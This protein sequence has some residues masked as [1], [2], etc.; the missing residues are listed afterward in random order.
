MR[1]IAFEGPDRVGK[2]TQVALVTQK[3]K[4]SGHRIQDY[5]IP[6]KDDSVTYDLI[7]SF[8]FSDKVRSYPMTFQAAQMENRL[9]FQEQVLDQIRADLVLVDRWSLS[10][11]VYG[12]AQGIKS[13]FY[14]SDLKQP[15][16]TVIFDGQPFF[17]EDQD[18]LE[19]DWKLQTKV[20]SLYEAVSGDKVAHI[21]ANRPQ[22]EVTET[23]LGLIL[24]TLKG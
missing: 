17:K 23:I 8:L 24:V 18:T 16:L 9:K 14:E 1:L 10:S 11:Q 6:W 5:K 13:S 15:D 21:Q 2:T 20:R 4:S 22:S 3:L 7:Y 12:A 19:M